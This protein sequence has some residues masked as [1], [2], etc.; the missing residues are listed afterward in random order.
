MI[1]NDDE[2]PEKEAGLM[3]RNPDGSIVPAGIDRDCILIQL[4]A[5]A[6][7]VSGSVLKAGPHAV[8][9]QTSEEN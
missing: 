7:L 5:H 6:Q 9:K 2:N 3:L 4:G 8:A 1:W